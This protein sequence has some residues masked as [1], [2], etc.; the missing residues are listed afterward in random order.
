MAGQRLST[1]DVRIAFAPEVSFGVRPTSGFLFAEP[2]EIASF[3]NTITTVERNP[4]SPDRQRRKGL[5]TDFEAAVDMTSDL[6]LS[7]VRAWAPGFCLHE[8]DGLNIHYDGAPVSATG[9]TVAG[10]EVS[11]QWDLEGALVFARGYANAANNG[12]KKT[13][14]VATATSIKV[15]GLTAEASPPSDAMVSVVG[16][17]ADAGKLKILAGGRLGWTSPGDAPANDND[18]GWA[19]LG[20]KPGQWIYVGGDTAPTKFAT[21]A[22]N[23]W[24]K[25][26]AIS[27]NNL[28][29]TLDGQSA[30]A[31]DAGTAKTV[32]VFF[33]RRWHNVSTTDSEFAERYYRF[34]ALYRELLNSGA[35]DGYEYILGCAPNAW[36]IRMPLTEKATSQ[37]VFVAKDAANITGT[38]EAGWNGA[39]SQAWNKAFNTS[40]DFARLALV[41]AGGDDISTYLKSIDLSITNNFTAE[42]VLNMAGA[43]FMNL[44]TLEVTGS[45]SAMFTDQ[46]MVSSIRNNSTVRLRS[47]LRNED[48]AVLFEI[49]SCTL[50]GGGKEFS[51]NET[52]KLNIEASAFRDDVYRDSVN[53]Q[54]FLY[55]PDAAGGE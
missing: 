42:K 47:V 26:S 14:A 3:G 33:G 16:Y 29:A 39:V 34:E 8:G 19:A 40:T 21:A 22:A 24:F 52:V 35:D 55:L 5:V 6:T 20:I 41:N 15:G 45:I 10:L 53:I 32:Q 25:V 2:N 13:N 27:S 51:V 23:G 50:G 4:I 37:T 9:Y 11:A 12:L 7:E 31:A 17:Q 48:G 54:T 49:P 18:D 36:T 44:G 46:E 43:A 38:Q 28:E 1:N 30:L